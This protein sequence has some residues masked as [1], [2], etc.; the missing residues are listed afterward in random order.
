MIFLET[1]IV[2][3]IHEQTSND[4]T[5]FSVQSKVHLKDYLHCD[6]VFGDDWFIL[7]RKNLP[8]LVRLYFSS[9]N[10]CVIWILI[11]VSAGPLLTIIRLFC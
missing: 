7:W 3:S 11:N 5:S 8:I 1:D 4:Q 10:H 2:V 9:A 6:P